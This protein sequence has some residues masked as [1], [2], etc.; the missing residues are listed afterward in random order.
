MA[1]RSG[2]GFRQ[3]HGWLVWCLMDCFCGGAATDKSKHLEA[4]KMLQLQLSNCS[5]GHQ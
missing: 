1:N 3:L 4:A 2:G 5:S